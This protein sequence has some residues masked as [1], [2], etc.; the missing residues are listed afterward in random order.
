MVDGER[1]AFEHAVELVRAYRARYRT[2]RL[3]AICEAVALA[4]I[5]ALML[6][7]GSHG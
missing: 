3:I 5:C 4:V 6:W 7:G 1:K 2:A